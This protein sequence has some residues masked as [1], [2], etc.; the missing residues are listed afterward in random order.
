MQNGWLQL[1]K[2]LRTMAKNCMPRM[3]LESA[4]NAR[5]EYMD[6]LA[7]KNKCASLSSFFSSHKYTTNICNFSTVR[8]LLQKTCSTYKCGARNRHVSGEQM[9]NTRTFL[10]NANLLGI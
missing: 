5:N 10:Q 8:K 7:H 3:P 1:C 2:W 4:S 6:F 9:I